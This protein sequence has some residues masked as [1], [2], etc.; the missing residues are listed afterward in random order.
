MH[1]EDVTIA[2]IEAARRRID[3]G[4]LRTSCIEAPSLSRITGCQVFAK[5]DDGSPW[6]WFEDHLEDGVHVGEDIDFCLRLPSWPLTLTWRAT[7]SSRAC[8]YS[9]AKAHY[10]ARRDSSRGEPSTAITA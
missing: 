4:V 5:L 1:A 8:D 3:G 10:A 6:P 2:D 9:S 7:R